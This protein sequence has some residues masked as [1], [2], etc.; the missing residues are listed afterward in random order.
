[1]VKRT[2]VRREEEEEEEGQ[3]EEEG[4]REVKETKARIV[5]TDT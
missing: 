4:V 5:K 3:G 1:V 2:T